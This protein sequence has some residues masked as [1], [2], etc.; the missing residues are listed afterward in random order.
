VI[1]LS[2]QVR[3]ARSTAA[4]KSFPIAAAAAEPAD[5]LDLD[6]ELEGGELGRLCSRPAGFDDVERLLLLLLLL[7]GSDL[8]LGLG[9]VMPRGGVVVETL[10]DLGCCPAS[11]EGISRE[12]SSMHCLF[13][14]GSSLL[15]KRL[16]SSSWSCPP[17]FTCNANPWNCVATTVRGEADPDNTR[18][19]SANVFSTV[20][21]GALVGKSLPSPRSAEL[22]CKELPDTNDRGGYDAPLA[23]ADEN[24]INGDCHDGELRDCDLPGD[25]DGDCAE[26]PNLGEKPVPDD[27]LAESVLFRFLEM[28]AVESKTQSPASS[29]ELLSR[30]VT[31]EITVPASKLIW[32][33]C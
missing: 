7:A 11:S 31:I 22:G 12:R 16:I 1:S 5:D 28:V 29:G 30:G 21:G 15:P 14:P 10:S 3:A 24:G 25:E 17:P 6:S 19:S 9:D 13:S 4:S 26:A 18:C 20:A 8:R 2:C 33:E 27:T 23:G 32:T